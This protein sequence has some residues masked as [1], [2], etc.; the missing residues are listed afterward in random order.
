MRR[1]AGRFCGA[2]TH[3]PR[4]ILAENDTDLTPR[5]RTMMPTIDPDRPEAVEIV[6]HGDLNDF[7]PSERRGIPFERRINGSPGIKDVVEA[8]GIPHPEI[9]ELVVNGTPVGLEHRLAAGDRVA[10]FPH[11]VDPERAGSGPLGSGSPRFVLDG[12]LGRLAAYLRMCGFDTWYRRDAA[13]DELARRAADDD[14]ILLTRDLGLLRRSI[15]ARGA[16]VRSDRPERQLV[17]TLSRF[18]LAEAV[19]P[20]GRCLRCN[21][22][23]VPVEGT[24]VRELI[25]P[26]VLREQAEAG[27]RRCPDCGGIYWQGSH[28]RRMERLLAESIAAA[29]GSVPDGAAD[30]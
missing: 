12:H 25:P 7:L 23:L 2:A 16:F 8:A 1:S 6:V 10:V 5:H 14:R 27:F 18:R 26:R 22:M 15:V 9:G 30:G 29:R 11:R 24:A 20:F 19:R 17:E 21:G 4:R 28:H 3:H 13:D